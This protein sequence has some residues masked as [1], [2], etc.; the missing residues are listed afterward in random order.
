MGLAMTGLALRHYRMLTPVAEGTGE[1]LVLSDRFFH[2]FAN[3]FMTRH[4]ET[5][6]CGQSRV[7]FQWMVGRMTAEAVTGD[8]AFRMGLM[9]V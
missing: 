2:L 6:R 9:A 8:L 5:P 4:T 3:F 7:D 1:C